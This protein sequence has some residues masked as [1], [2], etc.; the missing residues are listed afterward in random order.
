MVRPGEE[1]DLAALAAYLGG[2]LD[3]FSGELDLE[4][5]P[6]GHS[7]LTY[8]LRTGGREYVLRRAPLGPLA[9]KAHD[10]VREYRVLQAVHPVFPRAPEVYLLCEDAAVIGSPFYLMERRAGLILRNR[11]P[12]EIEVQANYPER[13]SRAFVECLVQL[14]AIDIDRHDLRRLGKPEGFL[15]RQVKGWS[16]RWVRVQTE[17]NRQME[18]VMAW[19][20]SAIPESSATTLV[21]NDFK[22]DNVMLDPNAVDRIEAVLDWEMATVGDPL[23]DLG[24]TL[25]YWT[26]RETPGND[27]PVTAAPGWYTR[28]QLIEQYAQSS[29]RDL[30]ALPWHEVFGVFKLAVIVQQIYY[31][32]WRGQT[33]DERFRDFDRRV[34][35][36]SEQAAQMVEKIA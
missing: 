16:D 32:F 18:R 3:G 26:S 19:L 7:N 14:H 23:C 28:Q 20:A 22:L 24:L 5:F 17:P 29:G 27:Q 12:P 8:L 36:L 2:K 33:G 30:A 10:M 11:V 34:R 4:Q 21:H 15:E 13:V 6:E 25:C 31:R 1:V 9:P 35:A